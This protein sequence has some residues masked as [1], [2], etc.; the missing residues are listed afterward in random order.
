MSTP[1]SLRLLHLTLC[2][3]SFSLSAG[4]VTSAV[5][6]LVVC[7]SLVRFQDILAPAFWVDSVLRRMLLWMLVAFLVE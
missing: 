7:K 5:V 2:V 4:R 1:R 6:L 3:P